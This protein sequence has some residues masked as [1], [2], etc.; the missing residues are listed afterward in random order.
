M[1][2]LVPK[3]LD[4]CLIFCYV[5]KSNFMKMTEV[6][7]AIHFLVKLQAQK[8]IFENKSLFGPYSSQV[9]F[10]CAAF[11]PRWVGMCIRVL[12]RPQGPAAGSADEGINID[13]QSWCIQDT[14]LFHC[15]SRTSSIV[16]GRSIERSSGSFQ[17][18]SLF[19]QFAYVTQN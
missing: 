2:R 7:L 6:L 5:E 1:L 19:N 10:W 18:L 14:P 11:G 15:R 8:P 4:E 17:P 9:H 13:Y 12:L 3:A 16:A